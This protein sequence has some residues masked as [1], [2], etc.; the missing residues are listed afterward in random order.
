MDA[1][2][3]DSHQTLREADQRRFGQRI[4]LQHLWPKGRFDVETINEF[5]DTPDILADGEE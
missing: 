3:L 4:L 1:L 2:A 5:L